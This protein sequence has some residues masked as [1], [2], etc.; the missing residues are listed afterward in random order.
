MMSR[1]GASRMSS[2]LGL[3]VSPKMP[4]EEPSGAPSTLGNAK[5]QPFM[6]NPDPSTGRGGFGSGG[7]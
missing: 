3:K 7:Y 2:V 6:F 5:R 1:L 4:M